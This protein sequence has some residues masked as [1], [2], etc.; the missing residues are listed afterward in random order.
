M[1]ELPGG[2]ADLEDSAARNRAFRDYVRAR[3]AAH[4]GIVS[5][6]AG[7]ASP[8]I[9][10]APV[11]HDDDAVRAVS[12]ARAVIGN[13]PGALAPR[14]GISA[15]EV[16]V[17]AD[18]AVA[19]EVPADAVSGQPLAE[20]DRLRTLARPGDLV[21]D[22]PVRDLIGAAADAEQVPGADPRAWRLLGLPETRR[23]ASAATRFVGRGRDLALLR[24]LFGK[25]SGERA[26]QLVTILGEAGIGKS[27]LVTE[28]RPALQGRH[29]VVSAG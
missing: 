23:A 28:F 10:G 7:S 25:T 20:A 24:A 4:C 12:A 13:W 21:I 5:A 1:V 15:G 14:A 3:I 6:H 27:R 19:G 17:T 18:I 22:K 2:T 26:P 9:F 16:L 8:A 11:A 29:L